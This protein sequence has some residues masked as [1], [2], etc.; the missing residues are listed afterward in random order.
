M[1]ENNNNNNEILEA[2]QMLST[3]VDEQVHSV[4]TELK[5]EI[6]DVRKEIGDVRKEIGD[7]RKEIGEVR[8]DMTSQIG[9]LRSD[10]IDHVERTVNNAKGDIVQL[11]KTDRE[12]HKLFHEKLLSIFEYN[13]LA[14]PEEI[15]MLRELVA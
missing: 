11:L 3:H 4:K 15:A 2:I 13:K 12:R 14:K 5:T 9:K 1:I 6:G 7:V 10:L 8:K